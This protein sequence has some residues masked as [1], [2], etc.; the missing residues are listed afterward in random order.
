MR[1]FVLFAVWNIV[2]DDKHR[3]YY[4]KEFFMA[5]CWSV[6]GVNDAGSVDHNFPVRCLLDMFV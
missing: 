5:G 4:K 1:C 2:K 3:E 6:R